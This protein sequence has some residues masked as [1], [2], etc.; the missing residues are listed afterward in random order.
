MRPLP[1]LQY[2]VRTLVHERSRPTSDLFALVF[3]SDEDVV[4]LRFPIAFNSDCRDGIIRRLF[5][6]PGEADAQAILVERNLLAGSEQAGGPDLRHQSRHHGGFAGP[7]MDVHVESVS[8]PRESRVVRPPR[9]AVVASLDRL[10]I[11]V[12]P[13]PHSAENAIRFFRD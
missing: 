9:L 8:A 13:L 2:Q 6:K 12:H 10:P 3:F 7:E 11:L 1:P 5:G 4:L